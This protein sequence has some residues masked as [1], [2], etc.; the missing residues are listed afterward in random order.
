MPEAR[1]QDA[2][3]SASPAGRQDEGA[4][5]Q[6]VFSTSALD[7]R[8]RFDAW[9][10]FNAPTVELLPRYA[11]GASLAGERRLWTFGPCVLSVA[12]APASH[13]RRS[14]AQARRDG[15]DHWLLTMVRGGVRRLRMADGR[16]VTMQPGEIH[17]LGLDEAL[18][19]EQSDIEWISLYLPRGTMPRLDPCLEVA[20]RRPMAVSSSQL[21]AAFIESLAG[22]LPIMRPEDTVPL[23]DATL[24]MIEAG[25][26]LSVQPGNGLPATLEAAKRAQIEAIIRANLGSAVLT[27][28]RLCLLAG[29]SR[30]SL[31]RM[32]EPDGGVMHFVS[33]QRLVAA[34][35]MLA[36][37][38]GAAGSIARIAEEVGFFDH[39]SFCRAFRREF[40][41]APGEVRQAPN[42]APAAIPGPPASPGGFA[43]VLTGLSPR[44]GPERGERAEQDE[45]RAG[46][47][48]RGAVGRRD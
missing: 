18:E 30:S 25:I 16:C 7:A 42:P 36:D 39:S 34:R 15:L 17:V 31:Y 21:L 10:A 46:L 24:G 33:R 45:R 38:R 19:G 23:A 37:A 47:R 4:D 41:L 20:R 8:D 22:R 2:A 48:H 14:A 6:V 28:R 3:V 29:I 27:A 13:E 32:F 9:R 44:G 11:P 12:R 26:T 43:D 35:R 40:G 1:L 5:G